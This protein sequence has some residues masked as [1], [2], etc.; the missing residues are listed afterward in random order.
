MSKIQKANNMFTEIIENKITTNKNKIKVSFSDFF[1]EKTA[2]EIREAAKKLKEKT[3]IS[4]DVFEK[5]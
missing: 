1:G 3:N 5:M 2:T 4:D